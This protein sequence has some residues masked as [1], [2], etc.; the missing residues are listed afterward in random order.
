M[1]YFDVRLSQRYPTVEFRVADVCLDA[2]TAVALAAVAR[3]LVDTA[4]REW[5]AGTEPADHSVSLL[6]LAAWR[7]ARSGLTE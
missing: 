5:R 4:A 3:A 6:R 2:G 7:A 1:V